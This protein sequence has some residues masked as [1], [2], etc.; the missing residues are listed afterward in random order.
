MAIAQRSISI[1]TGLAVVLIAQNTR[2]RDVL[3]DPL[4]TQLRGSTTVPKLV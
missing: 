3:L 1:R 2:Q 4:F